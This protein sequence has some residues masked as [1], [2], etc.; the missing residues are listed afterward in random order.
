MAR[1]NTAPSNLSQMV[2]ASSKPRKGDDVHYVV[3]DPFRKNEA[4]REKAQVVASDTES[5]QLLKDTTTRQI[6]EGIRIIVSPWERTGEGPHMALTTNK[7]SEFA[8]TP[9]KFMPNLTS[10]QRVQDSVLQDYW[11]SNTEKGLLGIHRTRGGKL[12]LR[13]Q[14]TSNSKVTRYRVTGNS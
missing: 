5:G 14:V 6:S 9:G 13:Y 1:R 7:G 3:T 4:A 2:L 11:Y 8:Q 12:P 10:I